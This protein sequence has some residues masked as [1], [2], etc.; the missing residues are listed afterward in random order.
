MPLPAWPSALPRPLASGYAVTSGSAVL[1]TT[2][3]TGA[4]RQR[5]RFT[6]VPDQ[7]QWTVHLT[8]A[9]FAILEAWYVYKLHRGADW[10]TVQLKSGHADSTVTARLLAEPLKGDYLAKDTWRV[11]LKVELQ[12][13]PRMT[14]SQLDALLP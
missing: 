8:A 11:A 1:R 14:E 13:L 7:A 9:Q 10:F 2:M 4:A 12:A 5:Q 3:D 6:T